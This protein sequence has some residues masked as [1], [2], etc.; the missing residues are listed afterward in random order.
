[1][2]LDQVLLA[3]PWGLVAEKFELS[4]TDGIAEA[5]INYSV[6]LGDE[7]L[8]VEIRD[9]DFRVSDFAVRTPIADRELLKADSVVVE[10]VAARW[11]E[12]EVRADSL[13]IDGASADDGEQ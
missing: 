7:G 5:D 8:H 4:V 9:S 12:Q 2:S 11:P 3:R 10:N 6:R 13:T 1:M